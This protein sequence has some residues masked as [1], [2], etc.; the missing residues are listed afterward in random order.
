[1]TGRRLPDSPTGDIGILE[2]GDYVKL[3]GGPWV[4]REG[5][6][7]V[8]ARGPKGHTC[9]LRNHTITE[10]DDGTLTVSPSIL[11]YPRAPI[12]YSA[13][14]RARVAELAGEDY[15]RAHESGT[16]GWHGYLERGVWREC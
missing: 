7:I 13:E 9:N 1:M 8:V 16:P 12:A 6:P 2:P 14:E 3:T 15:V 11:V 4:E 5:I 10:H